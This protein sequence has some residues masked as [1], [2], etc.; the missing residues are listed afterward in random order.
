MSITKLRHAICDWYK[1]R[2]DVDL[3]FDDYKPPSFLQV[4]GA[5]DIGV[6]FCSLPY[7]SLL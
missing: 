3:V 2:Y 4:P 1:R 6:E 5:K 7:R